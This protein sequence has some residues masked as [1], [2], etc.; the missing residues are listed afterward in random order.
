MLCQGQH[1]RRRHRHLV[2]Q[3][4]VRPQTPVATSNTRHAA[5]TSTTAEQHS[6][7]VSQVTRARQEVLRKLASLLNP[8]LHSEV[9][10]SDCH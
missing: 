7:Q 8:A 4:R 6:Q 1:C 9:G 5:A 3:T 10:R 2:S